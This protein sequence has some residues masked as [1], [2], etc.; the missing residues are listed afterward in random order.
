MS[1]AAVSRAVAFKAAK[2]FHLVGKFAGPGPQTRH[3]GSKFGTRHGPFITRRI[4]S[5]SVCRFASVVSSAHIVFSAPRVGNYTAL[6]DF[7]PHYFTVGSAHTVMKRSVLLSL[8]SKELNSKLQDVFSSV[9]RS[10]VLHAIS[11]VLN[12][13][14]SPHA[15]D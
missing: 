15:L 6:G 2:E 5:P 13:E 3:G 9:H 12:V 1:D 8:D 11:E 10:R 14:H 4:S 7:Q